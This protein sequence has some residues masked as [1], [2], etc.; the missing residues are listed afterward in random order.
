M[1]TIRST[2]RRVKVAT[3]QLKKD[4]QIVLK[5]LGYD[6]YDLGIWLCSDA[7]IRKY[8]REYR[9]KDKATD[10]LSFSYHQ[11]K[12]GERIHVESEEDKNLG[13]LIIAP[14]YVV[15]DAPKWGHS[16]DERMKVLLVHGICHLL[17]YDHETEE[18]YL[19]M[20]KE[21]KH[22]LSLIITR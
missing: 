14:N 9:H 2:Q 5:A 20:N 12:P 13:D 8:N 4:A 17:G 16:F 1:I 19:V 15:H 21:E 10:V 18:E 6:D 3:A 22:L 7:T 11:L